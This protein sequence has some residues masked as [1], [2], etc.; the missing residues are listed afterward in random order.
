MSI[1]SPFSQ[2]ELQATVKTAFSRKG[3]PILASRPLSAFVS[4]WKGNSSVLVSL[5]KFKYISWPDVLNVS[6][7]VRL[8]QGR[9]KRKGNFTKLEMKQLH[10]SVA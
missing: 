4:I 8:E 3:L 5:K 10:K 1:L 7:Q 2:L 6:M 9:R